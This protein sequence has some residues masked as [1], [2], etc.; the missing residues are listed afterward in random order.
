MRLLLA[1]ASAAHLAEARRHMTE[2]LEILDGLDAPGEI[3]T[4]L[5]LAIVRL[6]KIAGAGNRTE[7]TVQRLIDQLEQELAVG[8]EATEGETDPW[9]MPPV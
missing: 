8:T 7:T 6:E 5:D 4:L 1:T 2:A 3:G 9:A